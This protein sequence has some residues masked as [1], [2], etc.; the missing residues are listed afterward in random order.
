MKTV[1]VLRVDPL[2]CQ[3]RMA[4]RCDRDVCTQPDSVLQSDRRYIEKGATIIEKHTV[5][6]VNIHAVFAIK[7][8]KSPHGFAL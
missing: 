7:R 1:G 3:K 6:N 4:R 8:R 2:V 5:S